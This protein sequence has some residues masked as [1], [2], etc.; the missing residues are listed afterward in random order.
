MGIGLQSDAKITATETQPYVTYVFIFLRY[1]YTLL[2][3]AWSTGT[4]PPSM[5]VIHTLERGTRKS[6]YTVV[7][8]SN[9][10]NGYT[11]Y[12]GLPWLKCLWEIG[13]ISLAQIQVTNTYTAALTCQRSCVNV[14]VNASEFRAFFF[15]PLTLELTAINL[16]LFLH[17]HYSYTSAPSNNWYLTM[18]FFRYMIYTTLPFSSS[19]CKRGECV[20]STLFGH[21]T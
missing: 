4:Q 10:G 9:N 19:F 11:R 1:A 12:T 6:A 3:E 13:W 14:H 18:H 2:T 17:Y 8:S 5:N 16:T 15:L 20:I 21:L 7:N